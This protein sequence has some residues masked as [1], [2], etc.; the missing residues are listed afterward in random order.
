VFGP[1]LKS[2]YQRMASGLPG[3]SYPE[4]CNDYEAVNFSSIRAAVLS[5]RDEWRKRQQ[6]FARHGLNLSLPIGCA[7]PL[8]QGA[9]LLDNG[10]RL[11]IEKG[12]K[13]AAA[14]LAIPRLG[15]GRSAER[16]ASRPRSA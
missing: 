6:W 14:P 5:G 12:E 16:H 8:R 15:L 3:S 2:A 13:F 4:L 7:C 9:I 10:S 11:P 1:F